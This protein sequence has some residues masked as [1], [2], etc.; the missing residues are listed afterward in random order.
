MG[1]NEIKVVANGRAYI[2]LTLS[3]IINNV[4]LNYIIIQLNTQFNL[5]SM[6]LNYIMFFNNKITLINFIK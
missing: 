2:A 1:I 3:L 4:N 5:K 6:K